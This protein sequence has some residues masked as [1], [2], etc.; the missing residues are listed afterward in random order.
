MKQGTSL[1]ELAKELERQREVKRDFIV[2][3]QSTEM[4]TGAEGKNHGLMF[5]DQMV[6]MWAP[7]T[8]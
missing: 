2:P 3:T 8:K 5:G 7:V 1:V 4:V 6:G